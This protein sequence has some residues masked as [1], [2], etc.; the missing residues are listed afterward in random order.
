MPGVVTVELAIAVANAGAL[1]MLPAA[2]LP[3][4]LLQRMIDEVSA[5]TRRP[6]GVNVLV[7][8]LD[9]EIVA[10]VASQ[11]R[12][13][14]FFYG[15]PDAAIVRAV[16]AAGALASWQIGSLE[17]A[18]AAEAAGCDFVIAQGVEAGGHVRGTTGLLPLLTA[19]LDAVRIPVL[20][21]GGIAGARSMAAALAAGADGVRVGTRLVA[22]RES[23]AHPDYV[24]RLVAARAEDT[25]LTTAFSVMW[26]DAPHRVLRSSIE[27]AQAI[28]DDIVARMTVGDQ[29]LPV[30]RLSVPVPTRQTE[31]RVDAMALYAG[32]SVNEVRAVAPA[33]E[34]IR[35]LCDG[36]S[37]LLAAAG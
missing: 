30:P 1:A 29:V 15:D 10:S 36:A 35:E 4:P 23:G 21:A 27:A 34:I 20:A 25:E 11:V 9:A 13:V 32:Q 22:S 37:R 3:L 18:V 2:G 12:V 6:V 7:P 16:H 33:A 5:A 24:G 26:P 14:E 31:G 28:G 19:V 17:E 8:F